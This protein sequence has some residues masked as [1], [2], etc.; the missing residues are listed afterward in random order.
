ML[1][2]SIILRETNSKFTHSQTEKITQDFK[3]SLYHLKNTKSFGS[4][5]QADLHDFV[6]NCC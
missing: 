2:F 3:N 1:L 5:N 4:Q 6:L